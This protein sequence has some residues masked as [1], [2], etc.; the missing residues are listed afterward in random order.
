MN[1]MEIEKFREI[2]HSQ[3]LEHEARE[4]ESMNTIIKAHTR[5]PDHIF[6]EEWIKKQKR[7]QEIWDKVKGNFMFWVLAGVA[8]TIGLALW[9]QFV[10]EIRKG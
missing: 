5:S 3:I 8:A 6:L 2:L 7:K 10:G 9:H 1:D 4:S